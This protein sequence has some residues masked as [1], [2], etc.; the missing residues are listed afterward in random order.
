MTQNIVTELAQAKRRELALLDTGPI[1]TR[2]KARFYRLLNDAFPTEDVLAR[3]RESEGLDL[4]G[5]A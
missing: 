1:T 2:V 3:L 5:A 4:D